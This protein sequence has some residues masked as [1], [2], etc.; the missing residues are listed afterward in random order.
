MSDF[1]LVVIAVTLIYIAWK[2]PKDS[3]RVKEEAE[4]SSKKETMFASQLP[5][6]QG[7]VCE[8]TM[9]APS[10]A[11]GYSMSDTVTVV[12]SDAMWVLVSGGSTGKEDRMIRISDL[13]DV[14][15]VRKKRTV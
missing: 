2:V 3:V 11:F 1:L 4:V 7:E 6:M 10:S 15:V 13:A 12:D 9:K 5:S 8:V 14:R